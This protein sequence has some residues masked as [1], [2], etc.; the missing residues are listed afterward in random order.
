MTHCDSTF[1]PEAGAFQ[2]DVEIQERREAYKGYFQV[3]AYR[4]RH[5]KFNGEWT[6][7]IEREV[8][9]R[10]HAVAVLLY[11]PEKD[12][13]VLIRQFRIGAYAAGR[14]PWLTEVVAGIIGPG[15]TVEEV[16]RRESFEETGCVVTTLEKICDYLVSPGG[17]SESVIVFCGRTV[18]PQN[19]EIHGLDDE[20]EDIQVIV[21]SADR[22][23]EI[24]DEDRLNNGVAIIALSW[25][26]RH[27]DTLR[28]RW[29]HS[30]AS[31]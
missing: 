6:R 3:D 10:G 22:A 8:F 19:G 11:D 24:L 20:N 29:L 31:S 4:L 9:E 16:A 2:A 7:P 12:A 28:R 30:G 27:R 26:A 15:E 21:E 23:I 18:A 17:T 25:F 5:R 1:D 13:V 14:L